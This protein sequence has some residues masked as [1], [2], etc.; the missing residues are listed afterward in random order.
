MIQED[1]W[2]IEQLSEMKEDW[3]VRRTRMKQGS[4][5]VTLAFFNTPRM[6]FSSVNY[7]NAILLEG[8][9]P[10]GTVTLSLIE[11]EGRV[12]FRNRT[13]APYE[14]VVAVSGE[15]LDYLCNH[16]SSIATLAVGKSFFAD[17][18]LSYF[19]RDFYE[20]R[21]TCRFHIERQAAERFI[22]YMRGWLF[23]FS[24]LKKVV[25]PEHYR[26]IEEEILETLFSLIGTADRVS[27]RKKFDIGK[28]REVMHEKLTTIHTV[29]DLVREL[30]ISPRTLQHHFRQ[31][32]GFTPKQYLHQLRL[33]RI[34]EELKREALEKVK[35]SDMILRYGFFHPSHFSAEYKR[36]FGETPSQTRK[37]SIA[38]KR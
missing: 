34:R 13:L 23:Y 21:Q 15:T 20:M 25:G 16:A 33:G 24:G 1:P 18:F 6:Q 37:R 3:D 29:H 30:Q 36:A 10:E 17:T 27:E 7:S 28:V 38:V 22:A 26:K 12:S 5:D 19:G 9:P 11:S 4:V 35:I 31:T 8:T 2:E 32:L 14:L